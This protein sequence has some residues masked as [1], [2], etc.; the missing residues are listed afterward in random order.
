MVKLEE[1]QEN[2]T[3]LTIF[4]GA[5]LLIK[6]NCL[7]ASFVDSTGSGDLAHLTDISGFVQ[8]ESGRSFFEAGT[9]VAFVPTKQNWGI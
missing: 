1:A 9:E 2:H 7:W 4:K 8:L 5:V 3:D 6:G